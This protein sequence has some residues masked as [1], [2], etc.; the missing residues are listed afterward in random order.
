[1]TRMIFAAIA[2][3]AGVSVY[4]RLKLTKPPIVR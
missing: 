4:S 1:M 2:A 3:L